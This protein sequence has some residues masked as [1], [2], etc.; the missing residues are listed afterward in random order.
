MIPKHFN[1]TLQSRYNVILSEFSW[2]SR[3]FSAINYEGEEVIE[4]SDL[5]LKFLTIVVLK[6][7]RL[8][9]QEDPYD[10]VSQPSRVV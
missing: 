3:K 6:L 10:N 2:S 4:G 5:A 8:A 7:R 1:K 9:N